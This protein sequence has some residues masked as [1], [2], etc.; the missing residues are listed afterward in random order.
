MGGAVGKTGD[1][2]FA[3]SGHRVL[4]GQALLLQEPARKGG[5]ERRI[6]GGKAGELDANRLGQRDLPGIGR[7][8]VHLPA[9]LRAAKVRKRPRMSNRKAG[10][11]PGPPQ[12]WGSALAPAGS[13]ERGCR[14]Q[15][16]KG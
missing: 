7:M 10:T 2:G 5:D 14:W 12:R 1:S 3:G 9:T 16:G 15:I 13:A 4:G 11:P 6:E 8:G